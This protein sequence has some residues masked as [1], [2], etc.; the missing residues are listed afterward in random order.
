GLNA[1]TDSGDGGRIDVTAGGLINISKPVKANGTGAPSTGGYVHYEGDRIQIANNI[2]ADGGARG[3]RVHPFTRG[4]VDVGIGASGPFDVSADVNS[5]NSGH[6]GE[7]G[8]RSEGNDLS[9]RSNAR[10]HA[11]DGGHGGDGG[12]IQLRGASITAESSSRV[13]ADGAP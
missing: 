13:D 7:I 1:S 2:V 8:I 4:I 12:S 9:I 10:V 3:G 5:N 6:G 11:T